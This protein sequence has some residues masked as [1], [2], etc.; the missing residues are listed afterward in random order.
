MACV[1]GPLTMVYTCGA[2][3][4]QISDILRNGLV[5]DACIA[6]HLKS[7][8]HKFVAMRSIGFSATESLYAGMY[9]PANIVTIRRYRV[10]LKD[11]LSTYK[12][13]MKLVGDPGQKIPPLLVKR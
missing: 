8:R 7:A 10:V 12:A 4:K 11:A 3:R 13:I 9:P 2:W 6:R 5:G 1:L